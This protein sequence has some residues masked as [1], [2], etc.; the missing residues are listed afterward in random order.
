MFSEQASVSRCSWG[1]CRESRAGEIK[2]GSVVFGISIPLRFPLCRLHLALLENWR[3]RYQ[4]SPSTFFTLK[5]LGND[6]P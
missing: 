3:V 5:G 4:E 2:G 6:I 1:P